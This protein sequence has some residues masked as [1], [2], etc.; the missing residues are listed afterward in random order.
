MVSQMQRAFAQKLNS[1][2]YVPDTTATRY[3]C[4][5][6][7]FSSFASPSKQT[8]NPALPNDALTA[9]PTKP[10]NN[11]VP[12]IVEPVDYEQYASYRH[13]H[14]SDGND[15]APFLQF[16]EGSDDVD[17]YVLARK[18]RTIVPPGPEEDM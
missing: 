6:S 8:D 2:K 4:F 15:N 17:V 1:G 12:T 10:D 3:E 5:I 14:P 13:R 18:V 7:R 11:A 9:T 16:P